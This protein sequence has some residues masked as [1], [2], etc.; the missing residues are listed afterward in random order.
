MSVQQ[1]LHL[2]GS[3]TSSIVNLVQKL[4][5]LVDPTTDSIV[6]QHPN[7]LDRGRHATDTSSLSCCSIKFVL[8]NEFLHEQ[9]QHLYIQQSLHTIDKFTE[10][11]PL[12]S[13]VYHQEQQLEINDNNLLC[14]T[15][16]NAHEFGLTFYQLYN[17]VK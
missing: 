3:T 1:L 8:S 5:Q 15:I 13:A 2:S 10:C 17:K 14:N 9:F 16:L 12:H 7:P 4:I 11:F 6:H